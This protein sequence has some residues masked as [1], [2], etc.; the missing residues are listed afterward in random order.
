MSKIIKEILICSNCG[1]KVEVEYDFWQGQ[2]WKLRQDSIQNIFPEWTPEQR[3]LLLSGLCQE[4][5][6]QLFKVEK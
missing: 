2:R 6:D 4:C 1:K 5:W 3:E